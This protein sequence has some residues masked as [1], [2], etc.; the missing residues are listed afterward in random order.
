MVR[1]FTNCVL[2][3]G[4]ESDVGKIG[5]NIQKEFEIL[6]KA[7]PFNLCLPQEK[8]TMELENRPESDEIYQNE[9]DENDE[10]SV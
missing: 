10:A 5:L 4:S 2:Y 3:N 7:N 8:S 1:V 9:N 6:L